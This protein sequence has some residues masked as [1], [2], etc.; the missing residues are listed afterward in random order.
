MSSITATL[1]NLSLHRLYLD[2]IPY[3]SAGKINMFY[4]PNLKQSD[5]INLIILFMTK[6][7][8]VI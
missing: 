1:S 4:H 7:Q 6:I 8:V 5:V 2:F 3:S